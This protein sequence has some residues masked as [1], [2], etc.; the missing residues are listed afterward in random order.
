[1][2]TARQNHRL[3]ATIDITISPGG[4]VSGSQAYQQ[5][6]DGTQIEFTNNA[7]SP[8]VLV[9][10][11]NSFSQITIQPRQTSSP[12]SSSDVTINYSVQINGHTTGGPYAIQWGNGALAVSVTAS[13]SAFTVAV[14]VGG[15]IQ[16]TSDDAYDV[17]WTE[18]VTPVTVWSPQP[19]AVSAGE[20]GEQQARPGVSATVT[21]AFTSSANLPGKGTVKIG[22]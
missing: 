15:Y 6:P 5:V 14:P 21:C 2:A 12:I 1:M 4:T 8:V 13:S 11:N 17:A 7:T 16:F 10:L 19:A 18:G 22:S 9:F 20:N 3:N